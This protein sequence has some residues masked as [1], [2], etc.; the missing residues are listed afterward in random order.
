MVALTINNM[1]PDFDLAEA[2]YFGR[3]MDE[4][5]PNV[6]PSASDVVESLNLAAG[7]AGLEVLERTSAAMIAHMIRNCGKSP[8]KLHRLFVAKS[9]LYFET[10]GVNYDECENSLKLNLIVSC[11][12]L[13]SNSKSH[14]FNRLRSDFIAYYCQLR[15]I[16]DGVCVSS[17]ELNRLVKYLMDKIGNPYNEN[18][19]NGTSIIRRIRNSNRYLDKIRDIADSPPAV[20]KN[21]MN[22]LFCAMRDLIK[23]KANFKNTTTEGMLSGM[24]TSTSAG[25]VEVSF[26]E[27][28]SAAEPKKRSRDA[29]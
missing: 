21:E 8:R 12:Y 15:L 25:F 27:F 1:L 18:S 9:L 22:I 29:S 23:L 28:R 17:N 3:F 7:H 24:P 19:F 13:L 5:Y 16:C 6:L 20:L 11:P 14:S 10:A 4:Y 2:E 26:D